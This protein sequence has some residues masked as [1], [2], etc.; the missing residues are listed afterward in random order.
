[1]SDILIVLYFYSRFKIFICSWI[2]FKKD[3]NIYNCTLS[4]SPLISKYR[5]GSNNI[6]KD[7]AFWCCV[8]S[9]ELPDLG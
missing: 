9:D 8:K 6:H 1:M 7:L 4:Y 5:C 3:I 2:F